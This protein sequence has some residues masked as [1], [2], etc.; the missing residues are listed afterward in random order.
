MPNDIL[1]KLALGDLRTIGKSEEVVNEVLNNPHLISKLLLGL[2]NDNKGIRMRSADV[3]EKVVKQ[4]PGTLDNNVNTVIELAKKADQQEV[5]WHLAQIVTY[6]SLNPSQARKFAEIILNY[7]LDSKSSIVKV[8]SLTALV[9]LSKLTKLES[10]NVKELVNKAL[11][12]D[13]S[14]ISTRAKKLV[15]EIK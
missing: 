2:E 10:I 13:K 7:Y 14:S 9:H 5:Q 8:F 15:K 1:S 11:K 4:L 6:I 12:S 3:L